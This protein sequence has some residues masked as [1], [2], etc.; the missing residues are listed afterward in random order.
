MTSSSAVYLALLWTGGNGCD[1]DASSV[2][3]PA[4]LAL[5]GWDPVQTERG[6]HVLLGLACDAR[7]IV[8]AKDAVFV[9]RQTQAQRHAAQADVVRLRPGEV[10]PRRSELRRRDGPAVHLQPVD[11]DRALG[12][13]AQ[14][15]VL[16]LRQRRKCDQHR[17]R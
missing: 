15:H 16:D 5:L 6:V 1:S 17:S 7:L 13:A 3:L 11:D 10:L 4:V 14:Q 12:V 9:E 8:E 2:D